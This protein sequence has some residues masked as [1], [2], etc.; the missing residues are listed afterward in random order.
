MHR[1]CDIMSA[2]DSLSP[3]ALQ[4]SWDNCGLNIGSATQQV[5]S[6]AVSLEAT[7]EIVEALPCDSLLV[8][9]HP[10]LFKP[11]KCLDTARYPANIAQILLRKNIA[12]LALHTN[13]DKSHFSRLL[14]ERVLGF[15]VQTN[16]GFVAYFEPHWTHAECVASLKEKF[17]LAQVVCANPKP[18]YR[19]AALISGAGA[20][21]ADSIDVDCL[22]SGDMRYHDAMIARSMGRTIFDIRHFESERFFTP[23]MLEIL[24]SLGI[25]AQGYDVQQPLIIF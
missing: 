18:A 7:L 13:F 16:D 12:L 3:F 6:V 10:L 25:T 4:E 22:L 2:L 19:T 14:V 8:V 17:G 24:Q 11:L 15:A 23:F 5:A 21:M 1:I 9:H 20:S